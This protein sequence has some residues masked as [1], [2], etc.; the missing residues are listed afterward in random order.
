[1]V[2]RGNVKLEGRPVIHNEDGSASTIYSST[3]ALD[4]KG[5]IWAGDYKKAPR[6]ALIPTIVDGKFLSPSGKMP[7]KG[8]L[9]EKVMFRRAEEH[10]EK[11]REHLGVFTSGKAADD[12]AETTHDW[13]SY[14]P[15]KTPPAPMPAPAPAPKPQSSLSGPIPG[16]DPADA[17]GLIKALMRLQ[18]VQQPKP[19]PSNPLKHVALSFLGALPSPETAPDDESTVPGDKATS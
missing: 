19:T 8:S 7:K 15:P 18:S 16:G 12:Y 1:M 13:G 9:D 14:D 4:D 10:Y 17:Q 3:V 6:Y 5:N 11:T 2:S